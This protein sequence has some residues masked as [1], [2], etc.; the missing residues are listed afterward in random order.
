MIKFPGGDDLKAEHIK[1][2]AESAKRTYESLAADVFSK[3]YSGGTATRHMEER[4]LSAEAIKEAL[5]GFGE[6]MYIPSHME[7]PEKH[8]RIKFTVGLRLIADNLDGWEDFI[9]NLCLDK[10]AQEDS[11]YAHV[12]NYVVE[13][14]MFDEVDERYET[15][16]Y[17][18][19][20]EDGCFTLEPVEK[21]GYTMWSRK[22]ASDLA[23]PDEVEWDTAW[24]DKFT[25]SAMWLSSKEP[26]KGFT[27][28]KAWEPMADWESHKHTKSTTAPKK[29]GMSDD[30]FSKL[31]KKGWK[32]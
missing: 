8:R 16:R 32:K 2:L 12:R 22:A 20:H 13:G 14:P 29:S 19:C 27:Y 15:P 28:G 9:G 21:S 30:F 18:V 24:G 6:A 11:I 26:I 23:G 10:L 25:D 3:A 17:E 4:G 1:G 7:M 31:T 5:K